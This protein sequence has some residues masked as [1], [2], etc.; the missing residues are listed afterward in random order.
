MFCLY[1][2]IYLISGQGEPN[3]SYH[4]CRFIVYISTFAKPIGIYFTLLFSIERIIQKFLS[5]FFLRT[6]LHRKLFKL[7]FKLMIFL[8]SISIFSIRLYEVMKLIPRY[9]NSVKQTYDSTIDPRDAVTDITSNSTDRNITF[10]YC[11]QSVDI[12]GYARILSFYV[13]QHWFEYTALIII[14]LNFLIIIIQQCRLPR[15]STSR[16]SV[17]TKFYLSL[18]LCLITSELILSFFHL[19]VDDND[20]S[21]DFQLRGIQLLLFAFN[22]RCMFLPLIICMTICDALKEFIYELFIHR[23][24]LDNIDENDHI[25]II[26]D[27]S[28]PFASSQRTN[29]RLRRTFTKQNNNNNN[30]NNEYINHDESQDG[31]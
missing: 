2:Q 17:N 25:N 29:N 6:N 7:L 1:V 31:L 23:P 28:E 9:Q 15:T 11:F 24:Y 5:K 22:F 26:E 14:I 4:T 13:I 16:F 8:G 3:L 19:I 20:N 21:T 10:R 12:D 30:N 18:S 27:R